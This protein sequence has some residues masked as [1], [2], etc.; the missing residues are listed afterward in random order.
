MAYANS[1][2]AGVFSTN[3]D[4]TVCMWNKPME[5]LTGIKE[6]QVLGK[7]LTD[8][9]LFFAD[10]DINIRINNVLELGTSEYIS[11]RFHPNLQ[12]LINN[13]KGVHLTLSALR[14]SNNSIVGV[15]GIVELANINKEAKKNSIPD[16]DAGASITD[17]IHDLI[18]RHRNPSILSSAVQALKANNSNFLSI[19]SEIVKSNDA[20]LRMYIAQI[21]GEIGDSQGAKTLLMLLNDADTNVRY[22]AIEALGKLRYAKATSKLISIALSDDFYLSTA[23]IDSLVNIGITPEIYKKLRNISKKSEYFNFIA[24]LASRTLSDTAFKDLCDWINDN[25][26]YAVAIEMLSNWIYTYGFHNIKYS[27][28]PE[29]LNNLIKPSG[30]KRI[31]ELANSNSPK[32]QLSAVRLLSFIKNQESRN[33]MVELLA[34]PDLQ[35]E[36]VDLIITYGDEMIDA[37]LIG[38]NS[39]DLNIQKA[40]VVALGRIGNA[41]VVENLCKLLGSNDE[42]TVL[43]AGALAKIGERSAYSSLIQYIGHPSPVI[44]RAVIS[45]LNSISHPDMPRDIQKY[46]FSPNPYEQESAIRI[47]GYF[48]YPGFNEALANALNSEI[49]FVVTAAIEVM[50]FLAPEKVPTYFRKVI[51]GNDV[52]TKMSVAKS[53]AF[54]EVTDVA[55]LIPD[56]LS[57]PDPWLRSNTIRS[58][59]SLKLYNYSE[60][61]TSIASNPQEIMFVRIAAI[62]AL[63]ELKLA[64]ENFFSA[65]IGC[66]NTDL[67]E[68]AVYALGRMETQVTEQELI[69][70]FSRSNERIQ[71][72]IA[73]SLKAFTSSNVAEFCFEQAQTPNKELS[74]RFIDTLSFINSSESYAF[75][76][77][78]CCLPRLKHKAMQALQKARTHRIDVLIDFTSKSTERKKIVLELIPT[79]KLA[80]KA[81]L[82]NI[83]VN[84]SNPQIRAAAKRLK[85]ELNLF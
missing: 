56:L 48:G 15:I 10:P 44:R 33:K 39:D 49:T 38:I 80:E 40:S 20:E 78:L 26:N 53:I 70:W 54:C 52:K 59:V 81:T 27:N 12:S 21:I 66:E 45:A 31:I 8:V 7:L 36:L 71:K 63:G 18:H 74:D 85:Q 2:I 67:S 13:L 5:E 79:I 35:N 57:D 37:L 23:A 1:F 83:L 4:K 60:K 19:A 3:A 82:L 16:T 51:D 77:E 29:M 28:Y 62:Q 68:T 75:L 64:S 34:M 41:D 65:L 30:I 47:A 61:L 14:Q 58:M 32:K 11:S 69:N 9:H 25:P 72:A 84:D 55:D 6:E 22:H 24:S 50:P 73:D 43:T 46:A 42:I 17:V 76:L